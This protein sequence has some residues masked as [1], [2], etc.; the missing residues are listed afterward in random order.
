MLFQMTDDEKFLFKDL[1][2]GETRGMA[3]E[4]ALDFAAL[5]FDPEKTKILLDTENIQ[6]LYPIALKVS[7]SHILNGKSRFRIR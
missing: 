4:N 2:L 6:T 3:Y 5:G 1:T 7:K